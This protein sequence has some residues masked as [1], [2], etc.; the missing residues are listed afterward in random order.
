MSLSLLRS[1]VLIAVV[2]L[3]QLSSV[4]HAR[5]EMRE[6][7]NAAGNFRFKA[8][9][10]AFSDELVVLRRQTG[11][12]Q[13]VELKELSEKDQEFI[14]S[15]ETSD[16][17]KK[18]ADEMQTWTA[19]D[20]MKIEARVLDYGRNEMVVQRKLGQVHINGKKFSEIDPLHQKLVFRIVS[21]LEEKLITDEKGLTEWSKS[22][23]GDPK[24][25][26]LEGVLME[27]ASGDRIGIPFFLFA[28]EDQ[29][30]L[31]PGWELWLERHESEVEREKESFLMRSAAMAYQRQRVEQQQIEMLKLNLLAAASGAVAIWEVGLMPPTGAYARRISVV[32]PAVN[33]EQAV[34]VALSNYP[35]FR[36]VGVRR[37]SN[38]F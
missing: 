26:P 2:S 18:S 24:V 7:T 33:S 5:G 16:E 27:L 31:Q 15:K 32:V 12:L 30:V 9:V 17:V 36:L 38:R 11:E 10:I 22:L 37:A 3:I 14:R 13:A 29:Q 20:G 6:W 23:G 25:Y 28:F 19:K 4:P 35:G 1:I 8:E 34:Q 21:H